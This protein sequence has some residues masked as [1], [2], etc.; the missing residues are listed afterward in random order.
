MVA[1]AL[2]AGGRAVISHSSAAQIHQ[3][4]GVAGDR[5]ELI[6]DSGAN[7]R[8]T[9]VRLHY[10]GPLPERD[11]ERRRNVLVTTKLRTVCDLA[12]TLDSFLLERLLDE[13]L[14]LRW[15]SVP[16]LRATVAHLPAY[17]HGSRR[18]RSL[19]AVRESQPTPDSPLEQRVFSYLA[20]LQP[21]VPHF[22][23]N[24]GGHVFVLDAAWPMYQVAAEIDNRSWRATSRSAHDR[25]SRKLNVL[26]PTTGRWL[27]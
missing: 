12:E 4:A 1:A 23:A 2:A 15:W 17:R 8:L 16:A 25:E 26:T 7:L 3:F 13:G 20:P 6:V 27:T 24:L 10:V 5:P 18:L 19:L 14:V 9:G 22:Q 11:A 21:F